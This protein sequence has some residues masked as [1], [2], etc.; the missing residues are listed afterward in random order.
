M[1]T[2]TELRHIY[3]GLPIIPPPIPRRRNP[4]SEKSGAVPKP[5]SSPKGRDTTILT[6]LLS[7]FPFRSTPPASEA[8][9]VKINPFMALRQGNKAVVIAAV[10]AGIVSF[11]RFGQGAFEEWPMV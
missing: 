9:P 7:H 4:R 3:E 11:F 8:T 6:R 10:D 1:P 2:L 5:S